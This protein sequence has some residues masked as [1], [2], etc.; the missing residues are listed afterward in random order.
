MAMTWKLTTGKMVAL[1]VIVKKRTC[2]IIDLVLCL[3]GMPYVGSLPSRHVL[4]GF[5]LSFLSS[6]FQ[7][8]APQLCSLPY[9]CS[10][11]LC[12]SVCSYNRPCLAVQLVCFVNPCAVKAACWLLM[13]ISSRDG[14]SPNLAVSWN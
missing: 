13:V 5:G 3:V 6:Y 10:V 12:F 1:A 11:H 14:T 7:P 9:C 8:T 4:L 2:H